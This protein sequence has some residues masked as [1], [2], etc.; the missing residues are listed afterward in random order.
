MKRTPD[1]HKIRRIDV[2][3]ENMMRSDIVQKVNE[4]LKKGIFLTS[5]GKKDNTMIIGWGASG[6]MWGQAVFMVPVRHTRFT[7]SQLAVGGAF[8]LS[9]PAEGM[10]EAVRI[11]GSESG[12]DIDKFEVCGLRKGIAKEVD[13]PVIEGCLA[14]IECQILSVSEMNPAQLTED[15]FRWYNAEN[16]DDYH[17]LFFGK[18]LAAYEG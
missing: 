10:K 9:L 8:T 5:S 3:R 6:I 13:V 4:G 11:C 14:H 15:V 12:R 16:P 7:H 1:Q 2:R 18:I 17:S